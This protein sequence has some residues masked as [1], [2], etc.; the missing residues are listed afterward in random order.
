ME[1]NPQKNIHCFAR[2]VVF[3][4]IWFCGFAVFSIVFFFVVY[5]WLCGDEGPLQG[6]FVEKIADILFLPFGLLI[7]LLR[8]FDVPFVVAQAE[9]P[10]LIFCYVLP[11]ALVGFI[12]GF[13]KGIRQS[14]RG[15]KMSKGEDVSP[16]NKQ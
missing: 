12:I 13:L 11:W 9:I 7:M 2:G 1:A 8:K 3:G 10:S 16:A 4:L 6:T 14:G 15:G 5:R